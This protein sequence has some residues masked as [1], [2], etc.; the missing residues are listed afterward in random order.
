MQW[1]VTLIEVE[2]CAIGPNPNA[3]PAY[4][5]IIALLPDTVGYA[6]PLTSALKHKQGDIL[7]GL[8]LLDCRDELFFY[9]FTEFTVDCPDTTT[10]QIAGQIHPYFITFHFT[11]GLWSLFFSELFTFSNYAYMIYGYISGRG[12]IMGGFICAWFDP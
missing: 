1:C 8:A 5:I 4:I 11:E 7:Y 12:F 2:L 9:Y 10:P 3:D 6:S